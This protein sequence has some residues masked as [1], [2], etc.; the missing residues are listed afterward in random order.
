MKDY[1]AL[2]P[3]NKLTMS[4]RLKCA[5]IWAELTT[6]EKISKL[7]NGDIRRIR[8]AKGI[9]PVIEKEFLEVF[10]EFIKIDCYIDNN[11]LH[12]DRKISIYNLGPL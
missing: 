10:H 11:T 5:L 1:G 9:G 12:F 7:L 3:I 6:Y 4:N 2:V 8:C